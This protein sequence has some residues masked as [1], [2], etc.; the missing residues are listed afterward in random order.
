MGIN[1]IPDV[2]NIT[3]SKYFTLMDKNNPLGHSFDFRQD[4]AGDDDRSSLPLIGFYKVNNLAP[5]QR[6]K[7]AQGFVKDDNF[8]IMGDGL[9]KF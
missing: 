8:W 5:S 1:Q 2:V 3:L 9:R 6:I 7:A 4:M